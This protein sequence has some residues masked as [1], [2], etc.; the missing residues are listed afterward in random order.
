VLVALVNGLTLPEA[1][2]LVSGRSAAPIRDRQD[3]RARLPR[4]DLLVEDEAFSVES[5]FFL[6]QGRAKTG[7]ADVRMEA[8]LQRGKDNLPAIVWQRML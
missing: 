3:F 4:R 8:L 2:V 1:L 6:V 7:K 5:Q